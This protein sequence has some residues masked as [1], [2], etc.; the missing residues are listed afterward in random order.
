MAKLK[1]YNLRYNHGE[2]LI[3]AE[4]DSEIFWSSLIK[5]KSA[6]KRWAMKEVKLRVK[7]DIY[8]TPK[9]DGAA[10]IWKLII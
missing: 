10:G 8:Y 1:D 3:V 7:R 6:W 4:K 2:I 5:V 9:N